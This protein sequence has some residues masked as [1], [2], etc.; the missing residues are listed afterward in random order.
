MF[1]P[2][3]AA[4]GSVASAS[5]SPARRSPGSWNGHPAGLLHDKSA[6][7][8]LFGDFGVK[9]PGNGIK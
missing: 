6:W 8:V 5:E 2:L 9:W 3:V 4:A 7:H 1:Q